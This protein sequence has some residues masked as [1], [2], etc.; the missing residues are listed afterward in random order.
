MSVGNSPIFPIDAAQSY[1]PR[2]SVTPRAGKI[3]DEKQPSIT[4]READPR[5]HV[6]LRLLLNEAGIKASRK[7]VHQWLTY[8]RFTV[9][10]AVR[11]LRHIVGLIVT[12]HNPA[13][14]ENRI[15]AIWVAPGYRR[16]RLGVRL[17]WYATLEQPDHPTTMVMNLEDRH[18]TEGFL[19]RQG[20]KRDDS[21]TP[22]DRDPNETRWV[23]EPHTKHLRPS[24]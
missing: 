3:T 20:F 18:E 6:S 17:L 2:F 14:Q 23:H 10:V 7:R 11:N 15:I 5:D 16:R 22:D 12:D 19:R 9:W 8:Y 21:F 24:E 4:I 1:P 13:A